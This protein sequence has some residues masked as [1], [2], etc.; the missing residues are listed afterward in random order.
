MRDW[1]DVAKRSGVGLMVRFAFGL[2]RDLAAVPQSK[3]LGA[4]VKSKDRS[5][6]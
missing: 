6:G 2:Q 3:V 1:I 4:T 5:T